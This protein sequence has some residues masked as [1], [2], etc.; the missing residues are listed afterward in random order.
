[1][2]RE[3]F[4]RLNAVYLKKNRCKRSRE[5]IAKT[6]LMY[7]CSW[8]GLTTIYVDPVNWVLGQVYLVGSARCRAWSDLPHDPLGSAG[9]LAKS[10]PEHVVDQVGLILDYV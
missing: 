6:F 7:K 9:C 5:Y 4:R 8:I 3:I 2:L 1:V 10:V